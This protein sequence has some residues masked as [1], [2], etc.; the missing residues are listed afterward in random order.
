[1]TN[2]KKIRRSL[3]FVLILT[4]VAPAGL[5]A[6]QMPD[7]DVP[8]TSV[9][10]GEVLSAD[11]RPMA[12]ARVLA[13]H[14]STEK[15]YTAEPTSN[16]GGYQLRDLPYGYFDLAVE[17]PDGLFVGNQVVNLPPAGKVGVVLKVGAPAPTAG[18]PGQ[19]REFPGSD[20]TAMGMAEVRERL[21]GRDFWR[22][23]KGVAVIAG[24][25]ALS[26][27]A[28]AGSAGSTK[29]SSPTLP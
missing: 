6:Q 21:A 5:L 26:L 10:T 28:L 25:G 13:Y 8:G 1:M 17:T 19:A 15:L 16:R 11:A 9:L 27:L 3:A 2:T 24:A 4:S 20:Q 12:G 23:P 18:G 7:I 29:K 22:S 14:L